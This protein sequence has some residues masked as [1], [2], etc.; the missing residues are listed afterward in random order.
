MSTR[1]RIILI[2][3]V[4]LVLGVEIAVRFSGGSKTASRS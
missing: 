1:A 3:I 4:I 2:G